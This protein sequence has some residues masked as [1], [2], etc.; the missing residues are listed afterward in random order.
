[1]NIYNVDIEGQA[2]SFLSIGEGGG[3]PVLFIHA[4]GLSPNSYFDFISS[5]GIERRVIVPYLPGIGPS[6]PLS[7]YSM[8]SIASL[9]SDL[10]K[11]LKIDHWDMIGHSI[12]GYIGLEMLSRYS[13]SIDRFLLL[14]SF[15]FPDSE[16]KKESRAKQIRFVNEHGVL[17]LMKETIPKLFSHDFQINNSLLFD[18]IMLDARTFQQAG[19]TGLLKAMKDRSDHSMT[20]GN[21]DQWIGFILSNNDQAIPLDRSLEQLGLPQRSLVHFIDSAT[22]MSPFESPDEAKRAIIDFFFTKD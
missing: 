2:V 16:E 22:H 7:E 21:A 8:A 5:L 10:M 6:S 17:P 18:K 4:Y 15:C 14:H 11:E 3:N 20:L 1:M 12:G 19:V 9:L 13:S